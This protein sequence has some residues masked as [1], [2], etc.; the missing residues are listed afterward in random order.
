M[1]GNFFNNNGGGYWKEVKEWAREVYYDDDY[2]DYHSDAE[3]VFVQYTA[4]IK[5]NKMTVYSEFIGD[6]I[7]LTKQ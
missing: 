2:G 3:I 1:W 6:I 5:G 7:T 4:T